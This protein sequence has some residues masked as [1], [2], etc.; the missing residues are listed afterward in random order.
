M[1][2]AHAR[3][4]CNTLEYT[5]T[6]CNTLQHTATHCNTLQ[7]TATH[8]TLKHP[9]DAEHSFE[10]KLQH[11]ATRWNTLQHTA[12]HTSEASSG[13]RMLTRGRRFGAPCHT[14]VS[15]I[16]VTY[17]I[18]M[19]DMTH[20]YVR[21]DSS[22]VWKESQRQFGAFYHM[23]ECFKSHIGTSHVTHTDKSRHTYEYVMSLT[24]ECVMSHT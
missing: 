24:Y 11:I 14:H 22:Y 18:H 16:R 17:L 4:R 23:H 1:L 21:H 8:T 3:A 10:G 15:F 20:S 9:Q 6:H 5:A 12:T 7:H 2:S 13:C 19:R